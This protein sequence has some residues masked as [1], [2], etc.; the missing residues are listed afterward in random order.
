MCTEPDDD[1]PEGTVGTV[2]GFTGDDETVR[3]EFPKVT[4]GFPSAQLRAEVTAWCH[5][6]CNDM[7]NVE[8]CEMVG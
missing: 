6:S 7:L 4:W 2:V 8:R 5:Q 1:I 3:V